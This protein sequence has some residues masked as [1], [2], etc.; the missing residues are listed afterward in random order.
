MN[1]RLTVA[2][3]AQISYHNTVGLSNVFQLAVVYENCDNCRDVA[4]YVFATAART[5]GNWDAPST[6]KQLY[7]L[8]QETLSIGKGDRHDDHSSHAL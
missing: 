5:P 6:G 8:I 7:N 4:C 2:K 1:E 3:H